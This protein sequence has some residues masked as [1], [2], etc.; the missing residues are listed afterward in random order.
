[1]YQVGVHKKVAMSFVSKVNAEKITF[2]IEKKPNNV[3]EAI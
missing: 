3:R 2:N 1:M